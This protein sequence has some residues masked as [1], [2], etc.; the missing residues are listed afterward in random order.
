MTS[1][2]DMVP[3]KLIVTHKSYNLINEQNKLVFIGKPALT[4]F[5]LFSLFE[6][7]DIKILKI[8]T[9]NYK[10]EV[11]GFKSRK[12]KSGTFKKFIVTLCSSENSLNTLDKMIARNY[13]ASK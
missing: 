7:L 11:V 5:S 4:K 3:E 9:M 1:A 8:N 12:G 10:S 13:V 2:K 6:I